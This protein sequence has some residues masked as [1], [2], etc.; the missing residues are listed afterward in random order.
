MNVRLVG[1]LLAT[2]PILAVGRGQATKPNCD[3]FVYDQR[4]FW[5]STP[6]LPR[7]ARGLG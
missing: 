4:S 6:K 3:A 5:R 7:P 2:A 1:L